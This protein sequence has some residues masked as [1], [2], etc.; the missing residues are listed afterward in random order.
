LTADPGGPATAAPAR[1]AP[2]GELA[3]ALGG[4]GARGAYQLGFLRHVAKRYP[5]L[6]AEIL[7]GVSAGAV[8]AVYLANHPGSFAAKVEDLTRLWCGLSVDQ[9]F[10]VDA[11][12][13]ANQVLRWFAQLALFGGRRRFP[14]ME[15]LVDTQPL[16]E[17]LHR[18]LGSRDGSLPGIS[19]NLHAKELGA[20]AVTTTRY[21]TGQT[22]TWCQGREVHGQDR[23]LR[24]I[25]HAELRVEH[26]LASIALPLFFPAVQIGPSWYGDGGIRLHAPLAPATHLGASRIVAVSTSPVSPAEPDRSPEPEPYPP[27]AQ[28]LSVLH[29]AVFLDLLDQDALHL[30]RINR[31][32]E[33]R[34]D[35]AALGLR[36]VELLV[37]RPSQSLSAIATEYEARLPSPFR[38][39]L[40]RLGTQQA[41]SQELMSL[42][43]FQGN[44]LTRLIEIGEVDAD[45]RRAE[46]AHILE[47]GRPRSSEPPS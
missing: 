13:L 17:L 23:P 3:F 29:D 10:R 18:Q 31:L 19:R 16:V 8:N 1:A 38:F 2:R 27:P 24:R 25:A 7:T 28:I 21:D 6:R 32:L 14:Q 5:T 42:L 39:L 20:V 45:A 44:Y 37:L 22:I 9:V 40:R 11:A 4:G 12:S 30:K 35:A 36:P 43:M 26:V 33:G 47:G 41:R 46:I 15:G 34:A